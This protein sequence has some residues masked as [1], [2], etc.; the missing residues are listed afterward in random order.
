MAV[1]IAIVCLWPFHVVCVGLLALL[2]QDALTK[3]RVS[4]WSLFA[5]TTVVGFELAMIRL[6]VLNSSM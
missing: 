4:I 5:L 3:K 1:F 2:C 6:I